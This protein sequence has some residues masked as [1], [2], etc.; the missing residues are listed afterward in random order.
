[1]RT[2]ILTIVTILFIGFLSISVSNNHESKHFRENRI[3][4]EE[5]MTTPFNFIEEVL[6]I[7]DWM[8]KPFVTN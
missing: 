7:E 2:R 6:E 1:M 5:W 8:T 4:V 3:E